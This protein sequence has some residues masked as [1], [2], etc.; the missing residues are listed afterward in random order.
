[1]KDTAYI[2]T[3]NF[4]GLSSFTL[5]LDNKGS[6]LFYLPTFGLPDTIQNYL[7]Q[8]LALSAPPIF[9][10]RHD[11]IHRQWFALFPDRPLGW[12]G[13]HR[14]R[15]ASWQLP[16][17]DAVLRPVTMV[18]D[19]LEAAVGAVDGIGSITGRVH[20][21]YNT[22]LVNRYENGSSFIKWHADDQPWYLS[23]GQQDSVIGSVSLGAERWFE[24]RSV[25]VPRKK[26]RICLRSG[27][28]IVMG[29]MTQTHWEH[30]L[31][32]DP[33]CTSVRYNLTFRRVRTR[34]E[35]PE[36]LED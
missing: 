10:A 27:S 36:R 1:M 3:V 5:D 31:P 25:E 23:R 22:V 20:E 8:S 24:L 26:V 18:R 16:G 11:D 6:S 4:D 12:A 28:L 17:S 7:E 35:N 14:W 30:C 19:C 15:N 29:G 9:P 34:E 21:E 33:S 13:P 32:R 2:S